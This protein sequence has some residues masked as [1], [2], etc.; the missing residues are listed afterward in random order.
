MYVKE[1]WR[2]PVKSMRGEPL[3]EADVGVGG[4]AGDRLVHVENERGLVTAR[5]HPG[6]LGLRATM[7][8]DG[9]TLVEGEP[10]W[11]PR[12]G[13]LVKEAAGPTGHLVAADGPER[14]D[15][16]PL[17][18]AT[19]GAIAAFGRDGRR[20]RPNIIV[21]GVEGLAERTWEGLGM[22]I[23]PVGVYLDSLRA[24][25]VMTSYD[26]DSLEADR[27]VVR[28][29]YRRFGGTLALNTAVLRPGTVRLGDAV[30]V[31]DA[32]ETLALRRE[33][34]RR[35]RPG[36]CADRKGLL[37][38]GIDRELVVVCSLHRCSRNV[39]QARTVDGGVRAGFRLQFPIRDLECPAVLPI[40]Q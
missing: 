26:P 32:R 12:I 33:A 7:R 3:T 35:T 30:R 36:E 34:P 2:Y 14:F 15:V 21:G 20:L 16:L 37:L 25:C 31:L 23:G 27:A 28:D 39:G 18:V 13:D 8:E 10:W 17:L 38:P 5:T 11:H 24:R 29:I 1:L 9:V 22:M 4:T 19:D 6:L 40:D